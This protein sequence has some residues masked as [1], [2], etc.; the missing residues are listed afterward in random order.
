[1]LSFRPYEDTDDEAIKAMLAEEGVP[2]NGMQYKTFPTCCVE[3]EEKLIGFFTIRHEWGFPS[4]QHFYV[5][6]GKRDGKASRQMMQQVWR[7]I[8]NRQMIVHAVI[9]KEWIKRLIEGY[10]RKQPYGVANGKHWYLVE[11]KR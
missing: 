2:E 6:P 10:F 3:E 5:V 7:L 4:L 8:G 1:M 9:E 11:A